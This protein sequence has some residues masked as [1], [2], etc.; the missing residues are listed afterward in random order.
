MTLRIFDLT[1]KEMAAL[2]R[3]EHKTAG[4]HAITFEAQKLPSGIYLY[5]LQA[6]EFVETKRMVL[7]R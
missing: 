6:G 7:I 3:N 4:V 1:G 5:R 2:L